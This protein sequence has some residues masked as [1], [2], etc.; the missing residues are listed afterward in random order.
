MTSELD[1]N[2]G[3]LQGRN[4]ALVMIGFEA[5]MMLLL[6]KTLVKFGLYR[7][8]TLLSKIA[9]GLRQKK[10]QLKSEVLPQNLNNMPPLTI[11][12]VERKDLLERVEKMKQMIMTIPIEAPPPHVTHASHV[13]MSDSD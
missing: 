4:L 1:I 2:D 3:R 13:E 7:D 11:S 12:I 6:R 9:H 8:E 10:A 5:R